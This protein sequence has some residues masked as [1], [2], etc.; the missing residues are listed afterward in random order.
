MQFSKRIQ[1][2]SASCD[3]DG[4]VVAFDRNDILQIRST[5]E[6][7]GLVVRGPDVNI[8]IAASLGLYGEGSSSSVA[9]SATVLNSL[10]QVS[11][12]L[13]QGDV[14]EISGVRMDGST[15]EGEFVYFTGSM[16]QDLLDEIAGSFSEDTSMSLDA[17][18]KMAL[19]D[20]SGELVE[21][22]ELEIELQHFNEPSRLNSSSKRRGGVPP[23]QWRV[24]ASGYYRARAVDEFTGEVLGTWGSIPISGGKENTV[25]LPIGKPAINKRKIE[26]GEA[27]VWC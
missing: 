17:E 6:V 11:A 8:G 25:T 24:G 14:F 3:L 18:G 16:L 20:A 7:P 10:V 2:G 4:Y 12:E 21:G 9:N 23:Q 19:F 27:Y 1:S 15:F 26:R 5:S 13:D 22:Y